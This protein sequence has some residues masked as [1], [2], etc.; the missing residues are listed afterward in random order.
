MRTV[1]SGSLR[2][3]QTGK[4]HDGGDKELS[5]TTYTINFANL[6]GLYVLNNPASIGS[7]YNVVNEYNSAGD[8][9][10]YSFDMNIWNDVTKCCADGTNYFADKDKFTSYVDATKL[11]K[12]VDLSAVMDKFQ[13]DFEYVQ[14]LRSTGFS[15]N[16]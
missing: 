9:G 6:I 11:S 14:R 5:S 12:V 3:R 1:F 4:A 8:K 13:A 15:F 7:R 16:D 10:L 2:F